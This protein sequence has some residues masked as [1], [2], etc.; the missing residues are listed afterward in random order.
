MRAPAVYGRQMAWPPKIGALLPKAESAVGVQ[1][2]L[3]EYC[4]NFD[5]ENGDSKA[6]AFELVLGIT[7]EDVEYLATMIEAGVLMHTVESVR[8]N[9]PYGTNCVVTMS[10]KA[11]H[12]KTGRAIDVRTV[13]EIAE[14][15]APPRLITAFPRP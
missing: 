4:L 9:P 12:E 15:G 2:K 8:P 6:N 14:R 5:H 3:V 10:V 13:W 11:V 1:R 7:L